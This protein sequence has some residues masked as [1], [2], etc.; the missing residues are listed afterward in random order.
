MNTIRVSNGL[1]L[2]QTRRYVGPDLDP[3][4]LQRVSADGNLP[5]VWIIVKCCTNSSI[6]PTFDIK[7]FF[8]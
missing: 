1:D 6:I 8:C 7:Y 3:N 5:L 2:D 4:C